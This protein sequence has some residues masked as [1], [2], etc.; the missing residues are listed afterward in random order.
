MHTHRL[1]VHTRATDSHRLDSA[2]AQQA[3][4]GGNEEPGVRAPAG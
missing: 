3:S 1:H 2:L 4:R